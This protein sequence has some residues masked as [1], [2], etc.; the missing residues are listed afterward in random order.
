M[1]TTMSSV[2]LAN[3]PPALPPVKQ[4]NNTAVSAVQSPPDYKF[5]HFTKLCQH[6]QEQK[7]ILQVQV[8]AEV[9]N[10]QKVTKSG[11]EGTEYRERIL[12]FTQQVSRGTET[13]RH[14]NRERETQA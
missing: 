8:R 2:G 5:E 1:G 7:K 14:V 11:D 3:K 6:Y 13:T 10:W 12:G 4:N 9:H